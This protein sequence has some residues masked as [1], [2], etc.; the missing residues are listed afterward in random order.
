LSQI[1]SQNCPVRR[2][3]DVRKITPIITYGINIYRDHLKRNNLEDIEKVKARFLKKA[4][5]AY[6]F[7]RHLRRS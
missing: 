1:S 5:T 2:V 4:Y 7:R 3:N 6:V